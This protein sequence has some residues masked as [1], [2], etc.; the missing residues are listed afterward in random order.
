MSQRIIYCK[1]IEACFSDCFPFA[2]NFFLFRLFAPCF[3]ADCVILRRWNYEIIDGKIKKNIILE[4][5]I[6][7]RNGAR[8]KSEVR[9][10]AC[11]NFS[12]TELKNVISNGEKKKNSQSWPENMCVQVRYCLFW[13]RR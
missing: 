4:R 10:R 5:K 6:K 3:C 11:R 2:H 13:V 8:R 12:D 1:I 9:F 7:V